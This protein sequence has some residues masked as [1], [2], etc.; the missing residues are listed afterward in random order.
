MILESDLDLI[1]MDAA[2]LFTGSAQPNFS[3][4]EIALGFKNSLSH[5]AYVAFD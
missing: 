2:F 5:R 3:S 1:F 4:L